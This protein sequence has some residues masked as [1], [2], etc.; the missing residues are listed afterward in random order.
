MLSE[1]ELDSGLSRSFQKTSSILVY[2][3]PESVLTALQ[4]SFHIFSSNGMIT[5]Q[6]I[7]LSSFNSGLSH[8]TRRAI[9]PSSYLSSIL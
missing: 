6:M 8:S 1:K 9:A 4:K 3:S 7:P 5:K 2:T